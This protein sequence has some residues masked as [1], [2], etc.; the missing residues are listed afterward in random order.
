MSFS[1][2]LF[3]H[4]YPYP[5]SEID[6]QIK[7]L[8]ELATGYS[9][10]ILQDKIKQG[11]IL[12]TNV[13]PLATIID[14]FVDNLKKDDANF[15][16][17]TATPTNGLE[18]RSRRTSTAQEEQLRTWHYEPSFL[19]E[20]NLKVYSPIKSEI[21]D[22]LKCK[23]TDFN[24]IVKTLFITDGITLQEPSSDYSIANHDD[25]LL[26]PNDNEITLTNIIIPGSVNNAT[27]FDW[28]QF[29]FE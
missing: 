17:G 5:L 11:S 21:I 26:H 10:E 1:K 15:S 24:N 12:F 18:S 9:N 16:I 4:V 29:E 3:V 23:F 25:K 14:E 7:E 8:Q 27:L 22:R 2:S 28:W 20:E 6:E 13:K 19:F